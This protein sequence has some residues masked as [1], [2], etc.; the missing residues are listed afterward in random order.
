MADRPFSCPIPRTAQM[1]DAMV[2]PTLR[3]ERVAL[4]WRAL[5]ERRRDHYFE[6]YRTG[7]WKHY[8]AAPEFLAAMRASAEMAERWAS[9]AP[10]R[11]E[12]AVADDGYPL[13][14]EA[15]SLS[16]DPPFEWSDDTD[17]M[18]PAA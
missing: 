4:R 8:H 14:D 15:R 17:L 9:I 12:L 18:K 3:L 11:E 16:T 5:A 7:R 6:L 10:R 1:P 13:F 2:P